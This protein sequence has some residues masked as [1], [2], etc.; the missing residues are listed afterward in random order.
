MAR[1]LTAAGLF[2][3]VAAT[4]AALLASTSGPQ[5]QPASPVH[6]PSALAGRPLVASVRGAE[7]REQVARLHGKSIDIAD[8][9]VGQYRDGI[10]LWISISE[11]P[12]KA[13]SLLWA[14]NRR[15]ASGTATFSP[16]R[17]EQ[18]HEQTVFRTQGIGLEHAYY[19]RGTSVVW[20]AA[21]AGTLDTVLDDLLTE[22]R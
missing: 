9:L 19:Q 2:L 14:M 10:T 21:P 15:M 20:V 11:S 3:I 18:R 1:A 13:S 8:A 17:P 4:A 7:A 6:L 16:P 22:P 5:A 12:L